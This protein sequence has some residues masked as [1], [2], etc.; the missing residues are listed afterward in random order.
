MLSVFFISQELSIFD[1][2]Y[3]QFSKNILICHIDEPSFTSF[4]QLTMGIIIV[5]E[6]QL[7]S[8]PTIPFEIIF[9]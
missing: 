9:V 7:Q 3:L 4:A 6:L 5:N 8:S 1:I 2:L